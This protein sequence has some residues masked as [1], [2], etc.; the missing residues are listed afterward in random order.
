MVPP[1]D[2][3]FA[4][5]P[6]D[7]SDPTVN[8]PMGIPLG[9]PILRSVPTGANVPPPPSF[10]PLVRTGTDQPD[11]VVVDASRYYTGPSEDKYQTW[12][13]TI[14]VPNW[15]RGPFGWLQG[16]SGHP[17]TSTSHMLQDL[18]VLAGEIRAFQAGNGSMP[19][20]WAAYQTKV[21][22]E[23]LRGEI[24]TNTAAAKEWTQAM[25]DAD[26]AGDV[27]RLSAAI[28][29]AEAWCD[30]VDPGLTCV[31]ELRRT[32]DGFRRRLR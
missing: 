18:I 20:I 5:E 1:A 11:E 26:K 31:D 7:G 13:I 22:A 16:S 30:T 15:W 9:K 24:Q 12:A 25:E 23:Q 14:R 32:I 6:D 27:R 8:G 29:K 17:Y 10:P 4:F 21:Q 2:D 3:P 19:P 28:Q